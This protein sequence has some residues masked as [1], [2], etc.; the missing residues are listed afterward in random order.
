MSRGRKLSGQRAVP[1][2]FLAALA[3]GAATMQGT[4]AQT[5]LVPSAGGQTAPHRT[6]LI[7]KDGSYQVVMSYRVKGARVIFVS[8]ERG[9]AEEE[10]PVALVDFDATHRWEQQHPA[11][12]SADELQQAPPP[13][14]D[15]ELMKEEEERRA[16][17]PE[18]ATD[19][20]LP[21]QDSVLALDTFQGT[22]ELVPLSQSAGDLNKTTSHNILRGVINPMSSSH[23]IAQL[24]GEKA[25]VQLHVNQP[26]LYLRI[27]ED[28]GIATGGTPLTV[29][30]HGA[31]A[32]MQTKGANN[33]AA[34]QYVIVRV[35]VRQDA[36]VLASFNISRLGDVRQQED[37]VET[38][39]ETLPGGRWMKLTPKAPL[40]FGEYALMEV[41]SPKE[42]NLGVWDFGVHPT[43]PENRDVLKPEPKRP[44]T[45]ERRRASRTP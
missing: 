29:D 35:D 2:V 42:V 11:P 3:L 31:S 40:S 45:L 38:Q 5:P 27:G 41:I 36:R 15:P 14:I 43:A 7:L 30:T 13:V 18:V 33:S 23:Q 1:V 10:I 25:A 19:L 8:A 37:V 21:E 34:S 39:T 24:K 44:V 32:A 28:S 16:L 9:G 6:R 4:H 17:T 20:H 22:P 12:G 26:V